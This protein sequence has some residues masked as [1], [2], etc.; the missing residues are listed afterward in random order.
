MKNPTRSCSRRLPFSSPVFQ[1]SPPLAPRRLL[2]TLLA[3]ALLAAAGASL[4]RAQAENGKVNQAQAAAVEQTIQ[5]VRR[6]KLK[7]KVPVEVRSTEEAGKLLEAELE[8]E[9]TPES[10]ETDGRAGALIGLYPPG[11]NLKAANMSLLESQ[12]IAFYDFR[13]KTMVIVNGAL[14][15]E[16]P[17][18]PPELQ[19]KLDGMIL[20]HEFTHAL[21]DQNFDFGARDQALK[22]NG[23]RALALHSVAEGDATIAGYA[24]MLGRM[25]PAILATLIGNLK[26]FSQTFTGAANGVPRGVAEPLIFQYTD[27]VRFVAEAYQRGGW[28]AVDK[29]YADPPQSTQQ[30]IDP[31]LYFD[32]PTLPDTVTVAGYQSRMAGWHKS[33]EDTL[34]ELGLRIVFENARGAASPDLAIARRWAGDRIVMLRKGDAVSV[35]WL[36]TFREADSAAR[37]AAVYRNL[38][39]HLHGHPAVHRVELKGRAVLVA[40]GEAAEHYNRL[41]PA[42]WKASV[43]TPPPPPISPG[44]PSLHA[45]ARPAADALARRLAAAD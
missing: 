28:K 43:I 9:Y 6:L 27:G 21:Q 35:I 15:R 7:D 10:I 16:F 31:S 34:G 25:D 5:E 11:V 41:G 3:A 4:A 40:I 29:L 32:H 26:S 44:S 42:V 30:I 22:N 2:F 19:S 37:F 33:D 8:S 1:S 39:D 18:Q 20:A 14:E 45:E 13:K 36:L 17:G 12:V 24:C 23:D 38:L